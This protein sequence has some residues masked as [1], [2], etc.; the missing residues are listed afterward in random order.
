MSSLLLNKNGKIITNEEGKPY[1]IN[2]ASGGDFDGKKITLEDEDN[3]FTIDLDAES[4]HIKIN[5]G[6][7]E[8]IVNPYQ[9]MIKQGRD[10]IDLHIENG[11]CYRYDGAWSALLRNGIETENE[12]DGYRYFYFPK[13]DGTLALEEQ[14]QEMIVDV[15][16]RDEAFIE[17]GNNV[18]DWSRPVFF[19]MLHTNGIYRFVLEWTP[20]LQNVIYFPF[21]AGMVGDNWGSIFNGCYFISSGNKTGVSGFLNEQYDPSYIWFTSSVEDEYIYN[22][23]PNYTRMR[24]YYYPVNENSPTTYVEM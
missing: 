2:G 17:L 20:E 19:E 16:L 12:E 7:Q 13:K 15:D 22:N 8:A 11:I 3:G 6:V 4:G 14:M 9:I 18:I 5:D 10:Y 24:V 1:K 21:S 23:A